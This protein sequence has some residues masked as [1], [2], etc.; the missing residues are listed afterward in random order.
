MKG[1]PFEQLKEEMLNSP[2]AIRAYE[3][4]DRELAVLEL[5]HQMRERAGLSKSALA[6]MLG[7]SPSAITKLESNPMAASMKTLSRYANACGAY[8]DITAIYPR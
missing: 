1:V 8:I 6:R 4:A 3:E 5:L 2:E 7:I